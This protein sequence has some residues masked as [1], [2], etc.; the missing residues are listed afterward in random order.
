MRDAAADVRQCSFKACGD[1]AGSISNPAALCLAGPKSAA[2]TP[3]GSPAVA[4]AGGDS[5]GAAGDVAA[6]GT[7]GGRRGGRG[8][9]DPARAAWTIRTGAMAPKSLT[10]IGFS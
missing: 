1:S 8:S 7:S 4:A 5:G 3:D 10:S 2:R 9:L 6:E